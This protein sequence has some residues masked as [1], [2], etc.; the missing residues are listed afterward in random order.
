M[1][2]M[3]WTASEPRVHPRATRCDARATRE[4]VERGFTLVELIVVTLIIGILAAIAIPLFLTTLQQARTGALQ[5]AMATT[6]LELSLAL[7]EQGALPEGAER[8]ALLGAHGDPEI[9]LDLSA[10]ATEFC[11]AGVHAL[12]GETWASTQSVVPTRGATCGVGGAIVLP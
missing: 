12:V 10:T 4:S 2:L 8:T 9:A 5:A 1:E 3:N 7:V 11:L 6:R